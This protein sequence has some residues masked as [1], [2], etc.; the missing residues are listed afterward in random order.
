MVVSLI[1]STIRFSINLQYNLNTHILKANYVYFHF[2]CLFIY[3]IINILYNY[4][5]FKFICFFLI[6][7]YLYNK[8][9]KLNIC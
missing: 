9:Y 4:F 6:Y 5:L 7:I 2:S 8:I 1:V 3:F